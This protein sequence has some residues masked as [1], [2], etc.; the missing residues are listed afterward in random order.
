VPCWYEPCSASH[1]LVTSI[2]RVVQQL[3]A[4]LQPWTL[5][6]V[7]TFKLFPRHSAAEP[8]PASLDRSKRSRFST[9]SA[10][11]VSLPDFIW[12]SPSA[13]RCLSFSPPPSFPLFLSLSLVFPFS[14]LSIYLSISFS[15]SQHAVLLNTLC[16]ILS[17]Y[18]SLYLLL[19][20][21]CVELLNTQYVEK[22]CVLRLRMGFQTGHTLV[23]GFRIVGGFPEPARHERV[24]G[25][26]P[27][28]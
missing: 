24:P 28:R 22:D 20:T 23:P 25:S 19:N 18:L 14:I 9:R 6:R 26:T 21:Q 16:V 11:C 3:R 5:N 7:Q 8:K 15:P 4:S 1:R 27:W 13:S 12:S 17:L 2:A 10:T